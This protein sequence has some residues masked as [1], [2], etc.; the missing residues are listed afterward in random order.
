MQFVVTTC[1][2]Q[3]IPHRVNPKLAPTSVKD[4]KETRL[5]LHVGPTSSYYKSQHDFARLNWTD[6]N[7][8]FD[9]KEMFRIFYRNV[10]SCILQRVPFKQTTPR[11]LSLKSINL[12]I[13][14]MM[15]YRDR[16][17]KKFRRTHSKETEALYKKFRN[18]VA[19]NIRNSKVKYFPEFFTQNK[20]NKKNSGQE[21]NLL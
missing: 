21:L 19:N 3:L 4:V 8:A 15:Q 7:D 6:M 10:S 2:K 13:Q 9:V 16:L 1:S 18:R 5:S 20:G 14:K 17:L 12:Y 11:E